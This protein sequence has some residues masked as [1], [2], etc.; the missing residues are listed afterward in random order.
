V[1]EVAG[2]N[3]VVPTIFSLGFSVKKHKTRGILVAVL[4]LV[5]VSIFLWSK[6]GQAKIGPPPFQSKDI[7][8][9]LKGKRYSMV[10][11]QSQL[12]VQTD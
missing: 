7:E 4:L 10:N 5:P 6:Y 2:S 8:I 1:R 3:P 12:R 11:W 9:A